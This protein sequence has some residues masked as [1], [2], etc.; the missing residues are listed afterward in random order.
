VSDKVEMERIEYLEKYFTTYD[1]IAAIN[2]PVD[3]FMSLLS[4]VCP[5]VD[6]IKALKDV[7]MAKLNKSQNKKREEFRKIILSD[8]T[9]VTKDMVQNVTF[10]MEYLKT[11]DVINRISQ[12]DKV[13]YIAQLFKK[14]FLVK[15]I[16]EFDVD[17]YEEYLHRL[18]YLSLKEI[19]LLKSYYEYS[20]DS[21]EE[22]HREWYSFKTEI[23]NKM[24][25]TEDNIVSI[26]S[27]LC[28]T[29]FCRVYKTMFPGKS[30][31]ED[32]IFITDYFKQFVE[33]I[34][35]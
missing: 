2:E 5:V 32:P 14:S 24:S 10:I 31:K 20:R 4:S 12:N 6:G 22:H 9:M 23:A 35:D 7:G 21:N 26:F 3:I 27:G 28:M 15:D 30:G 1:K 34:I 29:G 11:V 13:A 19:Q 17:Q 25:T 18:D 8:T 16:N 33:K